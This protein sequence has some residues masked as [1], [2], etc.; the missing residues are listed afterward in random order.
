MTMRHAPSNALTWYSCA[1]WRGL[2]GRCSHDDLK[3][4]S[5]S[6]DDGRAER[7]KDLRMTRF[8]HRRCEHDDYNRQANQ[9]TRDEATGLPESCCEGFHNSLW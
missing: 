6:E 7:E 5:D 8:R 3:R 2:P 4:D 1:E 9:D